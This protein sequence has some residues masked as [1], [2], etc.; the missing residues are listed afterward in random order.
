MRYTR[1]D[2]QSGSLSLP[3]AAADKMWTPALFFPNEKQASVHH[4]TVPNTLIRIYPNGTMVKSVRFVFLTI[5]YLGIYISIL[6]IPFSCQYFIL[7]SIS[8]F[9]VDANSSIVIFLIQ[10]SE[11]HSHIVKLLRRI[12]CFPNFPFTLVTTLAT[13]VPQCLFTLARNE[14]AIVHMTNCFEMQIMQK[15]RQKPSD[16]IEHLPIYLYLIK[17]MTYFVRQID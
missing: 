10:T 11:C 1:C 5:F 17:E 12:D 4:V 7:G 8:V 3:A 16:S 14:R 15:A 2:G 6:R 9:C 13:L